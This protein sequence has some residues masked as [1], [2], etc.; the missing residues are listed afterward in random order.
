MEFC[1]RISYTVGEAP[2]TGQ[3]PPP[4]RGS[5]KGASYA[6]AIETATWGCSRR[7]TA[8]VWLIVELSEHQELQAKIHD[9]TLHAFGCPH[10]W[11]TTVVDALLLV[12]RPD[13]EPVLPF[14]PATATTREQDIEHT[15]ELV[16]KL[17][18][19]LG[20][21]WQEGWMAQG[22]RAVPRHY[23][24]A[25][26]K[27]RLPDAVQ[28][29]PDL[30]RA[31]QQLVVD[32]AAAGVEIRTPEDLGRALAERPEL[33]AG[34]EVAMSAGAG[35]ETSIPGEVNQELDRLLR[36]KQQAENALGFWPTVVAGWE[37]FLRRPDVAD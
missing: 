23:L 25:A 32:L 12:F 17:R 8:Q 13:K 34:P 29:A 14:S 7:F 37:A 19:A 26:L 35:A 16:E 28:V 10:C 4:R 5:D 2:C 11:K 1:L 15:R 18:Q 31:V 24:A 20:Q 36:G 30:R 22:L 9:G 27:G 21:G 6:Q 3:R 33:R